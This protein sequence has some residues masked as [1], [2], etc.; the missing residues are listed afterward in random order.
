M[1]NSARPACGPSRI[2]LV[3]VLGL[4]FLHLFSA[5]GLA[6]G[7]LTPP[8]APAP[9]MKTLNQL[10]PRT[11]ISLIPYFITNSG[12]YYVTTNLSGA[13]NTNGI[14]ISANHVSLD[15]C[16]FALQQ[17]SGGSF[18]NGVY[19]AGTYTNITIR[20]GT[21]TGWTF[22]S[23][24]D[25]VVGGPSA[26][27]AIERI[28]ASANSIGFNVADNSI[29]RDCL[30]ENN[31]TAMSCAG[32]LVAD[33]VVRGGSGDGIE[34]VNG[35]VR[36][37]R[38]ESCF[39]T[40]ISASSSMVSG[41]LVLSNGL[42]GISVAQPG[43]QII[44]N[45]CRANNYRGAGR[46]GILVSSSDNRIEANHLTANVQNGISISSGTTNNILIRNAVSGNGSANYGT[47]PSGN[48]FGPIVTTSGVVTSNALANFS[49]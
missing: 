46:A 49:Y 29:V 21:I 6:Q 17:G 31:F 43:C 12:S 1:K 22:G 19:V 32:G 48:A 9:S 2:A 8:G 34:I 44:N 4:P 35:S 41:C 42:S 36:D 27:V 40:G 3:F 26:N 15:F 11:P 30:C 23:G 13:S 39:G 37:C 47:I 14:T 10:E 45:T 18:G 5:T 28:T 33:C 25:A 24:V 16:G 38:V 7:S 20:N